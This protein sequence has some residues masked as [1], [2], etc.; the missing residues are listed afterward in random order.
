MS[1]YAGD[2][3]LSERLGQV[4]SGRLLEGLL[5]FPSALP[6]ISEDVRHSPTSTLMSF[7]PL[8][9]GTGYSVDC[10]PRALRFLTPPRFVLEGVRLPPFLPGERS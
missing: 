9:P 5:P 8:R 10:R 4:V 7:K 6:L 3:V 1:S 2:F